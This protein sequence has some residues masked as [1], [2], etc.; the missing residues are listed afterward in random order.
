MS[1]PYLGQMIMFG[2]NYVIRGWALCNGALLR[3]DQHDALFS[4]LGTTYGGDGRTTFGLPDMRGRVPL[5]QGSGPG[6][7]PRQIGQRFGQ[8]HVHL[9]ANEMPSHTHTFNA[10]KLGALNL[11]PADALIAEPSNTNIYGTGTPP[12]TLDASAIGDS[13]GGGSHPNVMPFQCIT[14]LIALTGIY[15]P[16]H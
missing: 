1:D 10:E 15:P 16:R 4:L 14:F 12:D 13:G 8:E 2:G 7:T 6:L 3:V 11:G 5:H 9:E